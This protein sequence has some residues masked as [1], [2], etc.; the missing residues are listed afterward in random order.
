[1][2]AS[3]RSMALAG[4][5]WSPATLSAAEIGEWLGDLMANHERVQSAR[6][7]VDAAVQRERVSR[8]DWFP[9]L[10]VTAN[11]GHERQDKPG[12]EREDRDPE[13]RDPQPLRGGR[14]AD[15]LAPPEA[16]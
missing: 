5:L 8:G 16:G 3:L 4:L 12:A 1:M 10:D 6:S 2:P 7:A 11:V 14:Q 9:T 13:P 15:P